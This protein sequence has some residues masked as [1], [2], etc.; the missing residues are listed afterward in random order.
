MLRVF[1]KKESRERAL[2]D[3]LAITMII[4]VIKLG[5]VTEQAKVYNDYG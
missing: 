5:V 1:I 2:F 4:N 3:L